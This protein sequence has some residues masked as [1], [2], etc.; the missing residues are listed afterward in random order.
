MKVT[1]KVFFLLLAMSLAIGGIM[2][3]AKTKVDPPITLKQINQFSNDIA[4]TRKTLA[5]AKDI[6]KEDSIL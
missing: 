5:E 1:I 2:V 4:I 6:L 3:Y